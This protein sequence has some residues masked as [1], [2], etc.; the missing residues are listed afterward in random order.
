MT[1][2]THLFSTNFNR[3]HVGHRQL[4]HS[5]TTSRTL[6]SQNVHDR[7]SVG[8][9]LIHPCPRQR[10]KPK[11]HILAT[12]VKLLH[13]SEDLPFELNHQGLGWKICNLKSSRLI[14]PRIRDFADSVP[15]EPS[16]LRICCWIFFSRWCHL[17]QVMDIW[18]NFSPKLS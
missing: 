7:G 10:A 17:E 16:K 14:N 15:I 6:Y 8:E 11:C 9:R 5:L 3:T 18:I 13:R 1:T 4:L 12:R 2:N